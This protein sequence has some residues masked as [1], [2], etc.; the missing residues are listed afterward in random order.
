MFWC[1]KNVTGVLPTVPQHALTLKASWSFPEPVSTFCGKYTASGVPTSIMLAKMCVSES[2]HGT[3]EF[4]RKEAKSCSL[5]HEAVN[6][7][8]SEG[9][10][11]IKWIEMSRRY[12]GSDLPSFLVCLLPVLR[13]KHRPLW[14]MDPTPGLHPQ[15]CLNTYFPL[16]IIDVCIKGLAKCTKSRVTSIVNWQ[17]FVSLHHQVSVNISCPDV[18]LVWHQQSHSSFLRNSVGLVSI[19]SFFFFNL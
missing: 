16:L 9:H 17:I 12:V 2:L 3:Q 11:H 14:G 10:F 5:E 6:A 1:D 13:T 4:F 15:P 7:K 19:F 18:D 8:G